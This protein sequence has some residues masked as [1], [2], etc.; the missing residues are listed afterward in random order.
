MVA[1]AR[2][3]SETTVKKQLTTLKKKDLIEYR[4]SDKTGGYYIKK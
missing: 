2:G 4:D 1:K 3:K